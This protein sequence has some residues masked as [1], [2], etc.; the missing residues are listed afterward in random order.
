LSQPPVCQDEEVPAYQNQDRSYS[1]DREDAEPPQLKEE[2]EEPRYHQD[3]SYSLD[4]EDSEPPPIKEEPQELWCHQNREQLTVEQKSDASLV[5]LIHEEGDQSKNLILD[6][7]PADKKS[8]MDTTVGSS[9]SPELDCDQQ[10]L[11]HV[12]KS[13]CS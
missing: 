4:Q 3:R 1:L 9:V 7:N 10:L 12:L 6:L 2:P 8:E 5:T 11:A 13:S